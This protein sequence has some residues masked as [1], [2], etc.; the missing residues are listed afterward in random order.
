MNV[1]VVAIVSCALSSY[2]PVTSASLV[3]D[4]EVAREIRLG[5]HE[6][7]LSLIRPEAITVAFNDN[8]AFQSVSPVLIDNG[9]VVTF[10][11]ATTATPKTGDWVAAYSPGY[12]ADYTK[13]VPVK[14]NY[15]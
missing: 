7:A 13:T 3:D 2:F 15:C 12:P 11:F 1:Y 4:P 14:Y 6:H 8:Y 10:T 9:D 5:H